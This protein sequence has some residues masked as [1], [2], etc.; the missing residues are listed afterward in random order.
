M[1]RDE[2]YDGP[3]A[4]ALT[5]AVQLEYVARYGSPDDGPLDAHELVPPTGCFVVGYLD[6]TPVAMGGLRVHDERT[7]EIKRMFVVPE[8]RG[9]GLSRLVLARLEEL[10]A[11]MGASRLILETGLVQPEAMSL[12]ETSGYTRIES[13]GHYRDSPLSVCYG[14]TLRP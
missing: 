10:G 8:W 3:S 4:Q 1:L 14:K 12:Y 13:F 6:T 7:V 11:Q 5:A 9:R 2:P